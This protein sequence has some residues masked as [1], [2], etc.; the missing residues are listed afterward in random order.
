MILSEGRAAERRR[1]TFL[2]EGFTFRGSGLSL[3]EVCGMVNRYLIAVAALLAAGV[4]L[5]DVSIV[6]SWPSPAQSPYGVTYDGSYIWVSCNE[7][8]KEIMFKCDPAN[9]SVVSSFK[10]NTTGL[11]G[12]AFDGSYLWYDAL[13]TTL[14]YYMH[15]VT[16][17]GSVLVSWQS[18]LART[19][20]CGWD[21]EYIW[22]S[23]YFGSMG[24]A[25][26]AGSLVGSFATSWR[27]TGVAYD[28]YY[29]WTAEYRQPDLYR[30]TKTGS[31]VASYLFPAGEPWGL[32][33]DGEY[34]WVTSAGSPGYVY[35][36]DFGGYPSVAPASF[37]RV[38]AIYH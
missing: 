9:G 6:A 20:G 2:T 25:T 29:L 15:K 18:P 22:L 32:G 38:R 23:S 36:A 33:F 1:I 4:A 24:W 37:G 11:F 8:G 21:G 34:L 5:G 31:V 28:G 19:V 10:V 17:T 3:E 14:N 7:T 26:T 30:I 35:K 13:D 27:P 16:D 12:C